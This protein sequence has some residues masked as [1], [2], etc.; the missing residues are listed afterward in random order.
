MRVVVFVKATDD[1]EKGVLPTVELLEA[2][3]KFNEEL[4][5]AGVMQAGDGL[6][7][8]SQGKRV[9]FNGPDRMVIDGPFAETKELIA[10]FWMVQADSLAQV[11]EMFRGCPGPHGG[12]G[13]AIEIRQVFETCDFPDEVLSP[14]LKAREEQL[15]SEVSKLG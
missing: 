10:G 2:M 11:I 5:K 13:E 12:K 8:S 4:I 14:E 7:P 1:S 6:K 15:R 9:A 3:G